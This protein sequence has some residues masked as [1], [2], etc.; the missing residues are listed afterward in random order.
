[1]WQE[2]LLA[3]NHRA[4]LRRLIHSD[5]C[6]YIAHE[7]KGGRHRWSARYAFANRSE[8]IKDMFCRSCDALGVRWTRTAKQVSIYRKDSVAFLDAFIGPKT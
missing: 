2:A 4:F 6:R 5:G 3:G 8:D 1:V 7:V